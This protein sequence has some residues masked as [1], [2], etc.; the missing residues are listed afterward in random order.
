MRIVFLVIPFTILFEIANVI[1]TWNAS[2]KD[3][4]TACNCNNANDTSDE[5]ATVEKWKEINC[6]SFRACNG[7]PFSL[8]EWQYTTT[9]MSEKFEKID[10]E[11]SLDL[12]FKIFNISVWMQKSGTKRSFIYQYYC[13]A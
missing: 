8:Y 6:A 1:Y 9:M 4:L 12:H 11:K 13:H 7:K 5:F 2:F 10:I 3:Q